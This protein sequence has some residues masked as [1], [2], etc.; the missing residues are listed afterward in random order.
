MYPLNLPRYEIKVRRYG[1]KTQILDELRRKYVSLTPEEW[2][3]QHF[4]HFLMESLGYPASLLVNEAEIRVGEKRLRCDTVLYGAH[5]RPRMVMEYKAP[6]VEITNA[7][8]DQ[9]LAYNSLLH[10]DYVV[11]SNGLRH[12][13]CRVD[14]ENGG[15]T[16]LESIP[17]YPDLP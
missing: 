15:C 1:G 13:C 6:T 2:V 10:A 3:R 12:F 7:V 8:L 9:A 5:G 4:T 11:M 16:F 17:P 14:R